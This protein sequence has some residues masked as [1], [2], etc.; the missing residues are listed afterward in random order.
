M[1]TSTGESDADTIDFIED[2]V[3]DDEGRLFDYK[4]EMYLTADDPEEENERRAKF[5]KT[6]C[7]LA[8]ASDRSPWRFIIIGFDSTGTFQGIQRLG[9]QGGEHLIDIDDVRLQELLTDY[10]VPTP[11]IDAF[12]LDANGD[13]A[14]VLV[15]GRVD[16]PPTVIDGT[17]KIADGKRAIITE[18]QSYTRKGSRTTLMGHSEHRELVER[19]ER[20]INEKIQGMADDLSQVVG[21]TSEELEGVDLTVTSSEEGVPLREIVTTEP[22]EDINEE[23][24]AGVKTWN[25]NGELISSRDTIYRYY[26]HRDSLDLTD[27][28]TEYL[29]HSCLVNYLP[30]V[31]WILRYNQEV[32]G[33]FRS[34]L[35]R[36]DGNNI[37]MVE[38]VLLV[39]GNDDL[40]R[41]IESNAD[42]DYSRSKAS[43][44]ADLCD[45]PINERLR[46]Y[47]PSTVKVG[48]DEY[49]LDELLDGSVDVEE[50]FDAVVTLVNNNDTDDNRASF[51]EIELVKLALAIGE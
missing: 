27:E 51:R 4:R 7:A 13:E 21:I 11:D 14:L 33:V 1:L 29:I 5:I 2:N 26:R 47:V 15:I 50:L 3:P 36:V 20:L 25:T 22:A 37:N 49:S 23:L 8:N 44:Y 16:E 38:H 41:E 10:L 46:R 32:D 18:G 42:L 40:L 45:E 43:E 6:V 17:I 35:N 39:L 12:R 24:R 31:E 9:A 28:I 30:G 19:R 48:T 34:V